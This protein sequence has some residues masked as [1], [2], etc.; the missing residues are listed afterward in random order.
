MLLCK[1]GWSVFG[2]VNCQV[3]CVEAQVANVLVGL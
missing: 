1:N 3:D 2:R